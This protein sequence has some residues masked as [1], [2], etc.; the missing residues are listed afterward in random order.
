M[1]LIQRQHDLPSG[2]IEYEIPK[3]KSEI[4]LSW[5]H[6][7]HILQLSQKILLLG[8]IRIK[9]LRQLAVSE[10]LYILK[11]LLV[12]VSRSIEILSLKE[13]I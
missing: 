7:A 1:G 8:V 11:E 2:H 13:M 9:L 12:K 4:F 10:V 3:V 5:G 6:Q